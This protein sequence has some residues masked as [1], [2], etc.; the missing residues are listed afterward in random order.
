VQSPSLADS[1]LAPLQAAS[2]EDKQAVGQA[3]LELLRQLTRM[4]EH[5]KVHSHSPAEGLGFLPLQSAQLQ[6]LLAE[7]AGK[8]PPFRHSLN[9]CSLSRPSARRLGGQP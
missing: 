6:E 3:A 5:A 7:I 9:L 4:Q 8:L 2:E 1:Q